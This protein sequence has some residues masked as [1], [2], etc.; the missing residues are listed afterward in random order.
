MRKAWFTLLAMSSVSV[1]GLAVFS[2]EAEGA[3][4]V[5]L[6]PI[7]APALG[8][9]VVRIDEDPVDRIAKRGQVGPRVRTELYGSVEV[10]P[11]IQDAADILSK[12]LGTYARKVV[13]TS[14]ARAPEDQRRL[15]RKR[16]YRGWAISRSKHL[17]GL[18]LD[19]GFVGRRSSMWR[20]RDKAEQILVDK[21][22]PETAGLL[23]VVR[24]SRCIHVEIDTRKGRDI[25]EAR[26]T[27]LADIGALT[28]DE[29]GRHPVPKL[30]QYVPEQVW[31]KAPRDVLEPQAM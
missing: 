14:M 15:M 11:L 21:L 23:R 4:R 20:I 18:A 26:K 13:V 30:R 22:G 25:I 3:E 24:E 29:T 1:C 16:R 27:E 17:M 9:E 7:Y 10:H 31:M 19:L 8:S 28:S 5:E 12:E 2:G 6:P